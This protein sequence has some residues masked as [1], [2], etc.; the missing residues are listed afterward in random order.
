VLAP[1]GGMIPLLLPAH[2]GWGSNAWSEDPGQDWQVNSGVPWD[3]V[4][5]YIT[6]GWESW[7]A[8]FIYR[9]VQQAWSKG[10]TPMVT[11]Y[12][13]LGTPPDCGEGGECYASKLQNSSTVQAYLDSLERAA[14][15]A[16]GSLPVIFNLEPDF[17]GF[18]Q[19]LSNSSSPPPGVQPDDPASYPV[20][21]SKTGYA[22]NLAGFG[23]YIVDLIH[24]TAPNALVAPMASM[25][26]TNADP[27]S[28][29][30]QQAVHM[31][32]RTAAFIDAMGGAQADLLV[33]EWSDR[34]AG[35]GLRPWWDDSDRETPRP[36]RAILWANSL[37]SAADKRL[38]LW[39]M[40]VGNMALD[41]SCDHYQDN[42]AAYAFNHPRDLADAGVVGML[43]GS[44]ADCMT[45][46]W[47]DGGF[48]A[49]QGAIAYR[50]PDPPQALTVAGING[51]VVSLRWDENDEP[52]LWHY[53]ISYWLEA[54]GGP[55]TLNLS[56]RNTIQ[57]LLPQPGKW[58]VSISALDAMGNESDP[59]DPVIVT[60]SSKAQSVYLPVVVR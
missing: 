49:A 23:K 43:F 17:Y 21:L 40:P 37:S 58:I 46:V 56:R 8:N 34:D 33:V 52:D 2:I 48:V 24:T 25:W 51:P 32:Q 60:T 5:Q 28:V 50:N 3:Y 14:H 38:F 57:L 30:S 31:A 13:M 22:N 20:A 39:Q 16:Q 29:T 47:T 1:P 45:Q 12:L 10:Y 11:V 4:Y 35:S 7:G 36:T 41:N 18:M 54:D 53:Q 59:S 6:Y 42:R 27:Q 19:Q 9:F 44:G 26:A 15:Q 55:S